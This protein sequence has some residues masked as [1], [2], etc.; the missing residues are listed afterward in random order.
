ME[1]VAQ[2]VLTALLARVS[3]SDQE[4][5][6]RL[7]DLSASKLV[8]IANRIVR[9][10][11]VANEIVQEAFIQIWCNSSQYNCNVAKPMTWMG[12]IVRYRA[13]DFV[14]KRSSRVEGALM[15][16]EIDDIDLIPQ[17]LGDIAGNISMHQELN[18]CMML[19]S[20]EQ[21]KSVL[22]AYYYGYSYEEIAQSL[23]KTLSAMKSIIRRAI[24]RLQVCLRT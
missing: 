1:E 17:H 7:Y 11:D 3:L 8:G 19:L 5:F 22:M 21:Q 10:E 9:N 2:D 13:Y 12:S 6:K 23:S 16:A 20:S 4:A 15:P 14:R 24:A 18:K